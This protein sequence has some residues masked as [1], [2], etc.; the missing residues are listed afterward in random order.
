MTGLG[1]WYVLGSGRGSDVAG[2]PIGEP[3]VAVDLLMHM[4]LLWFTTL[5]LRALLVRLAPAYAPAPAGAGSGKDA[6]PPCAPNWWLFIS[7]EPD[8]RPLMPS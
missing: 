4:L 7:G 6:T 2:L 8:G 3:V 1:P 5:I